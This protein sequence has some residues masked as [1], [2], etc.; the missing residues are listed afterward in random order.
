M[1]LSLDMARFSLL[2]LVSAIVVLDILVQSRLLHPAR[3][4]SRS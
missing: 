2:A 3:L 1:P 4:H